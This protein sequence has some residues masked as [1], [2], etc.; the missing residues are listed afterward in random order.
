MTEDQQGHLVVFYSMLYANH[1]QGGPVWRP[2][3]SYSVRC[4]TIESETPLSIQKTLLSAE[5]QVYSI[6]IP[7]LIF[8]PTFITLQNYSITYLVV[9]LHTLAYNSRRTGALLACSAQYF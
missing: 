3:Y 2:P 6:P 1:H 8:F 5:I 4:L 7:H 9:C